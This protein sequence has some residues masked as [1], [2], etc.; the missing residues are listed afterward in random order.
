M[1][2]AGS[3]FGAALGLNNGILPPGIIQHHPPSISG[4]PSGSGASGLLSTG[5]AHSQDQQRPHKLYELKQYQT[6]TQ[7]P[8]INSSTLSVTDSGGGGRMS[9]SS[10]SGAAIEQPSQQA[11]MSALRPSSTLALAATTSPS[12]S[13]LGHNSK[14]GCLFIKKTI[15]NI[16]F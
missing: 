5:R 12:A 16:S 3:P 14:A 7:Q 13:H 2:L 10:L 6:P 1:Q 11:A 8:S 9:T 4:P 15:F